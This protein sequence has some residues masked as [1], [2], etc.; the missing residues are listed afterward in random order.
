L[1][2]QALDACTL[3]ID[4][5]AAA[6]ATARPKRAV[7]SHALRYAVQLDLLP[8]NPIDTIQWTAPPVA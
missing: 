1:V 4:G 7:F 5:R 8:A 2:R 6:A 3:T